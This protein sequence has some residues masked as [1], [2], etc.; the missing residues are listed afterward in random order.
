VR[1]EEIASGLFRVLKHE[2]G[3]STLLS[4][5]L[6]NKKKIMKIR[7]DT[8]KTLSQSISPAVALAFKYKLGMSNEKYEEIERTI[9]KKFSF[10]EGK[11]IKRTL[12]FEEECNF[13]LLFPSLKK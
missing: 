5:K 3:V 6:L 4:Q 11:F 7:K 12:N 9:S 8:L 1:D 13:P 2:P 10:E